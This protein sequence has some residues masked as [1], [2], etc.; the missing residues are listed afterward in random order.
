[1]TVYYIYTANIY[2]PTL[3]NRNNTMHMK[4]PGSHKIGVDINMKNIDKQTPLDGTD[5]ESEVK[6]LLLKL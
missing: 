1:M 6:R 4:S 2:L 3:N 5:D